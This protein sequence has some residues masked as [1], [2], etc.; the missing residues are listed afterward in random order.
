MRNEAEYEMWAV[1]I[2]STFCLQVYGIV[3]CL[4]GCGLYVCLLCFFFFFQAEDGI[5]DLTVTGVQTCALPILQAVVQ[6]GYPT[7]WTLS[8]VPPAYRITEIQYS[9]NFEDWYVAARM[10]APDWRLLK[11]RKSVV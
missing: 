10:S 1:V 5:R 9:R 8:F 4:R 3:G 6:S 2:G 11:D 7:N